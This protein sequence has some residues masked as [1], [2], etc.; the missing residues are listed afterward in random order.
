M[1]PSFAPAHLTGARLRDYLVLTTRHGSL[2]EDNVY[3]TSNYIF[4]VRNRD[5]LSYT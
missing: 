4:D 2:L 3:K 5:C 1:V